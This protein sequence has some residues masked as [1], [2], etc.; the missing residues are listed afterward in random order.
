MCKNISKKFVFG[1]CIIVVMST[2][3]IFAC[4]EF[5]KPAAQGPYLATGIKICEVDT[6]SAIIWTRLTQN[7]K[8]F[9]KDRPIPIVNYKN[10]KTAESS[11]PHVDML[12]PPDFIPVVEF[13]NG[14]TVDN[15]EG[16]VPGSPGEVRVLYKAADE[17]DW[18]AAQWQKVDTKRDFTTQFHLTNLMPSTAY[19]LKVE[20]RSVK[21]RK[22]GHTVNGH[23]RT[24][25]LPDTPAR[26]VFTVT[27]GQAYNDQDD[28]GGGYKIYRNMLKLNP[29]F[30]VHTGDAVY[31]DGVF[32]YDG[33]A[34][35]LDLA[36]WHWARTYSIPTNVEFHRQ[37]ASY[38][39]KDDHDTWM[40]DCW[41]TIETKYMGDFTFKQGQKVFLEQVGMGNQTYRTI[42]WGKNLQ[43]WLVEGRDYRSPNTMPDGPDKTIW[44][45]EQ[46]EWFKRTVKDSDAS[47]R[48]LI[49]PTPIVGPD[50]E[51]KN[52][53]HSN[54]GFTNE[55]NELRSFM[56]DQKNM[57]VI[58]GDRHWQYVSV[59]DETGLREYSCGPAS[60]KHA[61][62]WSNDIRLP[63]HRYLNVVGGFLEGSVEHQNRKPILIFRHYSVDGKVLNEDRFEGKEQM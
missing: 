19:Q 30:F 59:D 56:A 33:L 54:K 60:D 47:F 50:R 28:P 5:Q 61:T 25:S 24:A 17:S 21:D 39:M 48:V 18:Q 31:Y 2:L 57:V 42:R 14:S 23:F 51:A 3:V 49:S 43:I 32:F 35:S 58:C 13:P 36:R 45:E 10:P 4:S 1:E 55:G 16:S 34:K 20:S 22:K 15:L 9:G 38:F 62:G 40:D 52:D 37:V 11:N 46:K 6:Q 8:R 29:H 12:L 7:K 53:N 26:V 44:G 63:E 41:S 27:T